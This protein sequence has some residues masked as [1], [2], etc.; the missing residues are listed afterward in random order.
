MRNITQDNARTN[1]NYVTDT[2]YFQVTATLT[3]KIILTHATACTEN[4]AS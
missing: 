3:Q 1:D 4:N 2:P